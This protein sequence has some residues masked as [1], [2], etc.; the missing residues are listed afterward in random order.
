MLGFNFYEM[1]Q[2]REILEEH[3]A[4]RSSQ[5]LKSLMSNCNLQDQLNLNYNCPP[6]EFVEIFLA[7]ATTTYNYNG[8]GKQLNLII[9]L[10]YFKFKVV[11][12]EQEFIENLIAKSS[13]REN[14]ESPLR[15][16]DY[17]DLLAKN[18]QAKPQITSRVEA[19][20]IDKEVIVGY[21]LETL[22]PE[23]TQRV[24]YEGIF[25]FTISGYDTTI[26]QD[27]IIERMLRDLKHK[28]ERPNRKIDVRLYPSD[29][30]TGG[31]IIES[32]LKNCNQCQNILDLFL[33][34]T[35][36]DIVLVIWLYNIPETNR[37][38][39]ESVAIEFCE[40][41]RLEVDSYINKK[42]RS[43]VIIFAHVGFEHPINGLTSLTIPKEFETTSLLQWFR[44]YC[45]SSA[46][47]FFGQRRF[48]RYS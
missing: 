25:T 34:E 11:D 12:D 15:R 48:K 36:L 14:L 24:G 19:V 4:A 6:K 32:K 37:E 9:F 45:P 29:I 42:S 41:S 20:R 26:L 38:Q 31:Q 28:T 43:F 47:V 5:Y 1:A 10:K 2:L 46:N 40:K 30:L 17:N 39:M 33:P 23:F 21:D 18:R 27:Y 16:K 8:D 35:C 44:G 7:E 22:A 13:Q 3:F